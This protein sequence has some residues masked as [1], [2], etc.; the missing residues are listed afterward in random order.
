MNKKL[1]N[2]LLCIMALSAAALAPIRT[3]AQ[4]HRADTLSRQPAISQQE[5]E[6]HPRM[7]TSP[8]PVSIRQQ[9]RQLCVQSRYNQLLPI[10]T[11]S[12]TFYTAY[13]LSKGTNW[14]TGLPKGSYL[15][16]NRKFTIY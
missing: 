5:S 14:L 7:M 2:L 9:G 6:V 11:E 4:V 3:T 1:R 15:I 12:G 13:R 8:L 16:N 10:Y